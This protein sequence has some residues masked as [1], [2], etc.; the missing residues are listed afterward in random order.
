MHAP[1]E[2][3]R[4]ELFLYFFLVREIQPKIQPKNVEKKI[5]ATGTT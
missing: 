4:P 3:F 1:T 2:T 5:E